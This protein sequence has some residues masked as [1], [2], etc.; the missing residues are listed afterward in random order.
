MVDDI[1]IFLVLL[2]IN[3]I[4]A[5]FLGFDNPAFIYEF[6]FLIVLALLAIIFIY[7]LYK[8]KDWA[9]KLAMIYFTLAL[10]DVIYLYNIVHSYL[11]IAVLISSLICFILTTVRLSN[12]DYK[13]YHRRQPVGFF[14][15]SRPSPQ[16]IEPIQD[17]EY[18][19]PIHH[20]TPRKHHRK[21]SKFLRPVDAFTDEVVE[22]HNIRKSIPKMID[23]P[24]RHFPELRGID[25]FFSPYFK[26]TETDDAEWKDIA[27][28]DALES[29]G[30]GLKARAGF[31]E[32][33]GPVFSALHPTEEELDFQEIFL[34]TAPIKEISAPIQVKKKKPRSKKKR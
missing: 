34:D 8:K 11:L 18:P 6:F 27:R 29:K 19:E 23:E 28:W 33:N 10:L 17:M 15:H 14:E 32:S 31:A 16:H 25:E 13:N 1:A 3:F 21:Y 2:L 4:C 7:G 24:K 9:Y 26:D 20:H 30:L 12:Q 22:K 5:S